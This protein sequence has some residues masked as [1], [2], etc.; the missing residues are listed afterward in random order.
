MTDRTLLN[1]IVVGR[2]EYGENDLAVILARDYDEAVAIFKKNMMDDVKP[3]DKEE[4]IIYI[5]VV[6]E[7][8]NK[9]HNYVEDYQAKVLHH[10]TWGKLEGKE[11]IT[12]CD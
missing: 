10:P 1:Y 8:M 5:E 11:V 3:E 9:Y 12:I 2:I 6:V 7:V 4:T